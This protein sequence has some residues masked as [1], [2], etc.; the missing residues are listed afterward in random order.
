MC[1]A[2]TGDLSDRVAAA[3]RREHVHVRYGHVSIRGLPDRSRRCRR[4]RDGRRGRRSPARRPTRVRGRPGSRHRS[5]RDART[6]LPRLQ[7]W[8]R[9]APHPHLC[10]SGVDGSCRS[11]SARGTWLRNVG[12]A[13]GLRQRTHLR[14]AP[15]AATGRHRLRQAACRAPTTPST[16]ST[17]PA[18]RS[19]PLGHRT[20]GVQLR[21]TGKQPRRPGQ[22]V[23]KLRAGRR[24]T[25]TRTPPT[26]PTARQPVRCRP[27]AGHDGYPLSDGRSQL[28]G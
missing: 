3:A 12:T 5:L 16:P 7:G 1:R 23:P 9:T 14:L 22:G 27:G 26:P 15:G 13:C 21:G 8:Q 18:S 28:D 20:G 10:R 24:R 11:L 4:R 6:A 19:A 25:G 2:P 17:A